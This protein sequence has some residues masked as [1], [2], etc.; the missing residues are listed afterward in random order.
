MLPAAAQALGTLLFP[1]TQIGIALVVILLAALLCAPIRTGKEA[2]FVSAAQGQQTSSAR[3]LFWLQPRWACKAMGFQLCLWTF[4]LLWAAVYFLPGVVILV[5]TLL[6][7]RT[8]VMNSFIFITTI[9]AS[10]ALILCG[11]GFWY[12]TIQR[13]SLVQMI[14]AKQPR[15][16]FKNALRLSAARMD[17]HGGQ[18]L[19][20]EASFLGYHLANIMIIPMFFTLPYLQQARTCRRLDILQGN[21]ASAQA[22]EPQV[23]AQT[24]VQE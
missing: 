24:I 2:W 17:K 14:L 21:I 8:G 19:W 4:R 6:E 23:A 11:M 5:G 9:C 13:Y 10:S 20:L 18:M 12:A 1:L 3:I 16:R 22:M 7:A 15:V